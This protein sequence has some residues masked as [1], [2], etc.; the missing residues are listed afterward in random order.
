MESW[1]VYKAAEAKLKAFDENHEDTKQSL[2]RLGESLKAGGWGAVKIA[3]TSD[4]QHVGRYVDDDDGPGIDPAF[5]R[6]TIGSV[7]NIILQRKVLVKKR[8]EAFLALPESL[9]EQL[10]SARQKAMSRNER[11]R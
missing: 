6:T 7:E 11:R 1:A 5:L 2:I 9:R 3:T 4:E 10:C 8:E